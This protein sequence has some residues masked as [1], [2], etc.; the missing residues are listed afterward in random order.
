MKATTTCSPQVSRKS[1]L[2]EKAAAYLLSGA[3]QGNLI[4][5]MLRNPCWLLI[6]FLVALRFWF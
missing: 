1:E 5:A 3:S 6:S 4:T 2:E